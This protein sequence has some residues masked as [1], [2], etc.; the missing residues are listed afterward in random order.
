MGQPRW[1]GVA[2]VTLR[3]HPSHAEAAPG[4]HLVLKTSA[5]ERLQDAVDGSAP[6]VPA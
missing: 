2:W 3:S 4:A 1:T 5:P 6:G